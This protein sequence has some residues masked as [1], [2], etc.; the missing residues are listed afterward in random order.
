V[1]REL[2]DYLDSEVEPEHPVAR[3]VV[4]VDDPQYHIPDHLQAG[5]SAEEYDIQ[6]PDDY[7]AIADTLRKWDE[8]HEAMRSLYNNV[9]N[10]G[11]NALAGLVVDSHRRVNK[12]K[13]AK[14]RV[15]EMED[16]FDEV[17]FGSERMRELRIKRR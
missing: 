13:Y 1:K 14:R 6:S 2:I 16:K 10:I 15:R 8:R 7:R 17:E 12:T 5:F 9:A 4:G 11:L 3:A